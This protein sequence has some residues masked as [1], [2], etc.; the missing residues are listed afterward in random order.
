MTAASPPASGRRFPRDLAR[1]GVFGAADG[2]GITLGLVAG[3]IVSR[4]SPHAVWVAALAGGVAEFFSMANGQRISDSSSGWVP[5]LVIGAASLAGCAVPAVPFAFTRG[6]L[7][8]AVSLPLCA[9]VAGVISWLRPER[10][11]LAVLETFGLLVLT[12]AACA[13]IGLLT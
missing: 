13:A 4:Q 11:A 2:L 5:P 10:G 1:V 12:G 8:L 7:A 6:S 3:L 9:A